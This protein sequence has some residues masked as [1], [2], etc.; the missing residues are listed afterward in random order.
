MATERRRRNYPL[1]AGMVLLGT[2]RLLRWGA[3]QY[4][5]V[6]LA[7]FFLATV[8]LL[9]RRFNPSRVALTTL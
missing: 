8:W 4:A 1:L 6:P 9:R 7:F 2:V 5:D 3:L